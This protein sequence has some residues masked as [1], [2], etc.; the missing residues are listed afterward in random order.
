MS[1]A[2]TPAQLGLEAVWN[3]SLNQLE[4]G[5][6]EIALPIDIHLSIGEAGVAVIAQRFQ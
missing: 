3:T 2:Q 6:R 4:A 5:S 1:A